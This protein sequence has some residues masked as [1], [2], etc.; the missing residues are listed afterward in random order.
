MEEVLKNIQEAINGESNAQ[1]KYELFSEKAL[2]EG[3][4][5]IAYLF[6]ATAF[7]EGIHIRNHLKALATIL[8]SK[9]N[10]QEFVKIDEEKLKSAIKDTKSSLLDAIAGEMFE[11]KKMYK[12]FVKIAEKAG[13]DVAELSFT[14]ARY[15]ERVHAKLYSTTLKKLESNK[16]REIKEIYVCSICGNIELNEI[17]SKCPVCDHGPQFFKKIEIS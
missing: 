12:N 2:S 15:A 6:K 17:P 14:L 4:P 16:P 10:P 5:Q 8:G 13:E 1:R 9:T 3:L 7:A 11:F